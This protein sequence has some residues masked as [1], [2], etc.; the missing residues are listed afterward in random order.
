MIKLSHINK[1]DNIMVALS[2]GKDSMCLLNVLY[3]IKGEYNLTLSAVNIEHGIRGEDS[4]KDSLFV[5]NYCEKLNIPIK[6]FTVDAVKFSKENGY[7]IEQG[8]RILRYNIFYDLLK[9]DKTLKIA[10][11]HHLSDNVESVLFN[12]FRGTGLKGLGGINANL[13]RIIRPLISVKKTE[14]DEYIEKNEIPFVQDLTNF[15]NN[16]SRN[17]IRNELLTKIDEKFPMAIDN[18]NA[19]SHIAHEE[20]EFL[21]NLAKKLVDFDSENLSVKIDAEP[22]LLKRAII[23][24]LKEC[25]LKKDYTKKHIDACFNLTAQNNG[26]FIILA[27]D[28]KVV[29]EYE[30]LVFYTTFPEKDQSVYDYNLGTFNFNNAMVSIENSPFVKENAL[31]FDGDKI[32]KNAVIRTRQKGDVFTK[33]SGGTKKLKDYFIDKKIKRFKRDLIPLIAVDNQVLLIFGVEISDQIKIDKNTK[34]ICVATIY[35]GE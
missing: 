6:L 10:T 3:S 31:N 22:V 1:N 9:N 16:Y 23:I 35:K 26:T 33:F 21:D 13:N 7:S 11:A 4:K 18:I 27:N 15:D 34:K 32:P 17:F 14:I 2:G 25:G 30:N 12:L 8:A 24:T 19:F 28:V 20:D 29:K 5:K